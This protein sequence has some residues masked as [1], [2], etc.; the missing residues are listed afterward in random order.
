MLTILRSNTNRVES[1]N[2]TVKQLLRPHLHL[3][4]AVWGLVE[5][6]NDNALS[7]GYAQFRESKVCMATRS[8][9]VFHLAISNTCT[10]NY[11]MFLGKHFQVKIFLEVV[12]R[13][14][15]IRLAGPLSQALG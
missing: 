13:T 11:K 12:Y 10:D 6:V 9:Y 4:E 8:T 1:R 2:Q 3:V 7:A 5:C 15:T 14:E